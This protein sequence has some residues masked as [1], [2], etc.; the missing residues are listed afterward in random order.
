[1]DLQAFSPTE[2]ILAVCWM[3]LYNILLATMLTLSN[4]I[5]TVEFMLISNHKLLNEFDPISL[6]EMNGVALMKR[7]DTKF[8]INETKLASLLL[9][10]QGTYKVLEIADQRILHYASQ[11][12]DTDQQK[13]YHDHHNGKTRRVKIRIRNY[14]DSGIFFFEIKE[15]DPKGNTNKKR[16]TAASFQQG[17]T[18]HH[19]EFMHK[20][21]GHQYDLEPTLQNSFTRVTLV[22]LELKERI[23]IDTNLDFTFNH[24]QKRFEKLC[25]I[26][27][28]QETINRNSPVFKHLK[29]M[30][31][32]P[33]RVSK[34]CLG[35]VSLYPKIKYN[36]FKQKILHIN[37]TTT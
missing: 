20:V 32:H 25:I 7:K 26:E 12:F 11:Y 1:M 29:A 15:K 21:L 24:Q 4:E 10:L 18:N 14:V 2:V 23:T 8:I 33:Y 22:S 35:M 31:I 30:G 5:Y 3:I 28:K 17:I 34:Y 37:K 27:L 19:G 36:R 16:I 9:Q 6:S 13:F